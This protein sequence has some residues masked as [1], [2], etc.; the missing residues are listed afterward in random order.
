MT[1]VNDRPRRSSETT[2]TVSP[3][4]ISEKFEQPGARHAAV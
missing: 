3:A 2:V 1:P 4:D